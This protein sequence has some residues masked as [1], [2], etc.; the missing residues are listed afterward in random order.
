MNAMSLM[1]ITSDSLSQE[2]GKE[3]PE[4]YVVIAKHSVL[5]S[6]SESIREIIGCTD[7]ELLEVENDPVYKEVR[8]FIGAVQ[9]S[10]RIN[11]TVGW[12][13][14]EDTAISKL[15]ERIP[16]ERDSEFLLKVAAIANKAQR[17]HG[18]QQGVLDPTHTNGKTVISLTQRLIQKIQHGDSS[19]VE[20]RTLSISDGS[21][22]NPSFDRID[23]MLSVSVPTKPET[24]QSSQGM[25]DLLTQ[26]LKDRGI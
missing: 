8:I 17:R 11:Q 19:L 16:H 10:S 12:D 14:I 24:R 21:V 5:G 15:A 18:Q 1:K 25:V 3:I 20:E 13:F 7:A 23:E 4:M 2:L 26:S 6:D 22:K 9:A